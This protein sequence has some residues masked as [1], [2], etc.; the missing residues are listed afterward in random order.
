M[1]NQHKVIHI[2]YKSNSAN[3][4]IK[5]ELVELGIIDEDVEWVYVIAAKSHDCNF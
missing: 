4:L 2:I 5:I 1:Q 3:F